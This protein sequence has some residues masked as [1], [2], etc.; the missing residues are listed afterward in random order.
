MTS[1]KDSITVTFNPVVSAKLIKDGSIIFPELESSKLHMDG[2]MK[3]FLETMLQQYALEKLMLVPEDTTDEALR[4]YR[5]NDLVL[6][7]QVELLSYLLKV[8]SYNKK[9]EAKTKELLNSNT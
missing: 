4:E 3:T 6:R 9:L 1:T 8:D 2:S 7:V 5:N